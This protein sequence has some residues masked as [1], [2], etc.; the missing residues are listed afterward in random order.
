MNYLGIDYG[1]KR[2]G[3]SFADE[4]G[5]ALPIPPAIGK[6]LEDRL[7]QIS[8]VIKQRRVGAIV[9]GYPYNMDGSIGFKAKEVDQFIDILKVRF[10]LPIHKTDERLTS[11]Q[12]EFDMQSIMHKK[13]RKT[14][15]QQQRDRKTGD[16]DSRAATLILQE[17]LNA[18][19]G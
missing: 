8:D 4:L 3:L 11:A 19:E 1:E 16:I 10:Q 17:F 2:I 12:A 6:S 7:Q 14:I 15:A 5:I 18:L 13:K 9:I